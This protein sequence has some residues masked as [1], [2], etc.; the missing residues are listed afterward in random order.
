MWMS[1]NPIPVNGIKGELVR[2]KV[3]KS[4]KMLTILYQIVSN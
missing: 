3:I 1:P 4:L 2:S